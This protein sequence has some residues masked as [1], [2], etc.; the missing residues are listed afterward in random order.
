MQMVLK[1]TEQRGQVPWQETLVPTGIA[2]WKVRV[3]SFA[4]C[5]HF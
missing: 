2:N 1:A 4:S 5:V 3:Q